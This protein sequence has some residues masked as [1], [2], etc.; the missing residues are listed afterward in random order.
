M[1]G[2]Q[3]EKLNKIWY[4]GAKA[5]FNYTV[6]SQLFAGLSA[7]RR[8]LYDMGILKS[9]R[10]KCPVIIVGN[11][12]VGGV[13]KTPFTIWL[14]NQ[15]QAS[16]LKVGVVSR[17]YG[18]KREH[19]PLL[20]IPQTSAK[21][22]G[23]E[24]L[25]IAKNTGAPV[26]VG[27]NRVKAATKLLADYRVNVII[28]DDGMQHYALQRDLEIALIDA[29]YGL[30]NEKLLPLGPLREKKQRL[31]TVDMVI[32]KGKMP[33]HHYFEYQPFMVYEL[34]HI[35]NQKPLES[36]RN[37]HINAIAGIAH[38]ESFFNML[39]EQGLAIIK[40]PMADHEKLTE[41]HF[42][43]DNDY[44]VFITEKD[45]VK[46]ETLKLENVWVVV[47]KLVVKSETKNQVLQM[48]KSKIE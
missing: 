8:K 5:P 37:Q 44:P 45:A 25:L 15:L 40:N 6:L 4:K 21:A 31:E 39:S 30:G 2:T 12:S 35:K 29:K 17:G 24:A 32:Y 43:F 33:G 47:L 48:V 23:D 41:K 10:I 18:G 14:V 9:H 11:I 20:V 42:Q 27:K 26:F 13:G 3:Q 1:S 28:A 46:C 7:F 34:G 38:P 22:S 16:G 36:F 19:E